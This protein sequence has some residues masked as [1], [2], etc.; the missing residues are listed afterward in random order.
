[1]LQI[2]I[3]SLLVGIYSLIIYSVID[4]INL[5]KSTIV[6][7][8]ITGFSK[9]IIGYL[10]IYNYYCVYG[11]A[12]QK[13]SNIYTQAKR[14]KYILIES[15]GE[16]LLYVIMWYILITYIVN[17]QIKLNIYLSLV[18]IGFLLHTIMELFGIHSYYCIQH[19][20]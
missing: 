16:G 10:L 7:L 17:K 11:Y 20:M 2:I 15:L 19:C 18:I 13:Q 1:M 14:N 12:C 6:K 5:T 9:H 8:F 4:Y 3:E